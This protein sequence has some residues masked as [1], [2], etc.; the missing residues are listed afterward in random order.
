CPQADVVREAALGGEANAGRVVVILDQH[1]IRCRA[2]RKIN[3]QLLER[4]VPDPRVITLELPVAEASV[5]EAELYLRWVRDRRLH[6]L[7]DEWST[8]R[9]G[10]RDQRVHARSS[11]N[12]RR[13]RWICRVRNRSAEDQT[14]GDGTESGIGV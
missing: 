3:F 11:G 10:R 1:A 2:V 6:L 4:F 12:E 14:G 9:E 8:S 5:R 13:A 7:R